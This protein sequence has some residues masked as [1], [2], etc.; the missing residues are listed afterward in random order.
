MVVRST[1]GGILD[2]FDNY[3]VTNIVPRPTYD[4]TYYPGISADDGFWGYSGGYPGGFNNSDNE[5]SVG[6]NGSG[7]GNKCFVRFVNVTVPQGAEILEAHFN[8]YL[9]TQAFVQNVQV[10]GN[11]AD[12]AV[13]PTNLTEA[14]ALVPTTA[15]VH[16]TGSPP[17]NAWWKSDDITAIVQEITDRALWDSGHAMQMV[18]TWGGWIGAYARWYAID[19]SSGLYKSEL[20]IKWKIPL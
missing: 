10:Y 20:Y 18:F 9:T 2:P 5:I 3:P 14:E 7:T 16:F 6:Y 8:F 4:N 11:D 17:Y 12:D 19:Y 15:H 1:D 13:A